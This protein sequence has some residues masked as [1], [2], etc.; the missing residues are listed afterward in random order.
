M[1]KKHDLISG[2]RHYRLTVKKESAAIELSAET[3]GG[4][5]L[6]AK[7]AVEIDTPWIIA[8]IDGATHRCA[9]ARD[10]S[11]IWVSVRGRN[12]HFETARTKAGGAAP[13]ESMADEVRAPM[14]GTIIAVKV[15]PGARVKKG[16][17]LVVME[18]MK[19]EYR[20]E[21]ELDGEVA[22]VGCAPGD[23]LDVGT[24]LVKLE[25]RPAE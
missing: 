17:L 8:R 5:R 3:D 2:K 14:T 13:A 24:L 18:A 12:Y 4:H 16:D 22:R 19:M 21:A 20:L 25:P 11:G 9:V 23:M 7:A 6:E 10:Q 1:L 15:T